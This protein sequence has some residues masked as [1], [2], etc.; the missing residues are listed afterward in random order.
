MAPLRHGRCT[1]EH[2]RLQ[3]SLSTA[4]D[5]MWRKLPSVCYAQALF[6]AAHCVSQVFG[7]SLAVLNVCCRTGDNAA[8]SWELVTVGKFCW[9]PVNATRGIWMSRSAKYVL[10][11]HC[12]RHQR[13]TH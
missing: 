4:C 2:G 6:E 7:W 11:A 10:P 9:K 5:Q 8:P 13:L 3:A 12:K 1:S